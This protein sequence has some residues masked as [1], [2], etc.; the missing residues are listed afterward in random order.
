MIT[1]VLLNPS[2]QAGIMGPVN[3]SSKPE[4]VLGT[5]VLNPGHSELDSVLDGNALDLDVTS[6]HCVLQDLVVSV[7]SDGV[8]DLGSNLE[9]L[10][11]ASILLGLLSHHRLVKSAPC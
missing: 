4:H 2:T 5:G 9:G 10:V 3:V 11:V 7:V 1:E 6:L 8:V